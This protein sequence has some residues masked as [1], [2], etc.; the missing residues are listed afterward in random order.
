[1]TNRSRWLIDKSEAVS[2]GG[3]VTAMHPLAAEVGAQVLSEG[4][5]A[6]DAA[7]ATAFAVGVVEP[8]MS[9]VGG[10]AFL[11][12]REASSGRTMC[13]DG[14]S[15][16]P[17]A[18]RPEMFELLDRDQRSGM[19]MWRATKDDANNTGW[20]APAVPGMPALMEEAH[21]R[22]G[23][24]PWRRLLEPAIRLADEGFAVDFYVGMFIAANYER[25]QRCQASRRTFFKPSGAPLVPA[26]GF[27]PGDR[28]VQKD[29]ARTLRLIAE[30]GARVV[31]EGDVA[32]RIAEDM[33][34]HGG[35]VT[36]ADLAAHRTTVHETAT[37][38]SYRQCEVHGQLENSGYATV[39]EALNLLEG[40][41]LG[42]RALSSVRAE[43][44][45]VEA[46]RHAFLDRLRFLGD[47]RLM[48]V[49][50]QGLIAKAYAEV[51]RRSINPEKATPDATHGDPWPFDRPERA[52]VPAR[53]S[54]AGEG[55]TTHI[56]VVD[57][58]RNLVSLTS[59]LGA[60]FGSAVVVE[61]AGICLNNGT[62]WFD[63]EPGS[64]TSIGPG[65]RILSAAAP[66]VVTRQGQP[67]LALGSPGG[68]R[69]ISAIVQ[70]LVNAVD[71]G[72]GMQ[73][74]I[75]APRVHAEGRLTLV[76]DRLPAEV[77]D[78]LGAMGHDVT[79]CEDNL[80]GGQFARPSGIMVD[81]SGE[82]RAGVFQ[83]TPAA[84]IGI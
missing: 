41:E 40:F 72:L 76:S 54:G 10:I 31:Y 27:T 30:E 74:A 73:A 8:F 46:I 24:L 13:L 19:Y 11:V 81:A 18:I 75:S 3:M 63:P 79:V 1:M 29:L 56:T 71:F 50:Y 78:G 20:L 26:T 7:V 2:R 23:R 35:L 55:M 32:R 69:V 58:D 77:I 6:I 59:T 38:V 25:L 83:F 42:R 39:V 47:S 22:H 12:H 5:S 67:F 60:T 70:C 33:R 36:E 37:A 68:R 57:R 80:G 64:V 51:R 4:G 43:H 45:I 66:V 28:L 84:A 62:C 53:P 65:K 9:G 34:R 49:P 44:L 14:G 21:R 17:A 52:W 48:P 15:V 16:L 82:L 61:G